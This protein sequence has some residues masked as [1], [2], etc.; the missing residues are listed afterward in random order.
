[1]SKDDRASMQEGW[2][3][4]NFVPHPWPCVVG[5]FNSEAKYSN[6]KTLEPNNYFG[7]NYTYSSNLHS[8]CDVLVN[9]KKLYL[10]PH[11][12]YS[13]NLSPFR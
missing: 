5:K 6:S 4:C 2:W 9:F 7:E 12:T 1:M 10:T 11:I 3:K 8:N 13:F